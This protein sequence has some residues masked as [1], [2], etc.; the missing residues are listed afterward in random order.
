[1]ND[2]DTQKI[3]L[4]TG[5][6]LGKKDAPIKLVEF[7]NLRCPFC[8][9]WWEER[10]KLIAKYVA[11]GKIQ[12][13]IKLFDKDKASLAAGN[14]M[15][16]HVPEDE[17]ATKVITTIFE[18]QD[19]WGELDSLEDVANYAKQELGLTLQKTEHTSEAIKKE[20]AASGVFF[21]PTMIIGD[22]VFDQKISDQDLEKLLNS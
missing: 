7:T 8:K 9:Q 13:I 19:D 21:I 4:T 6:I 11:E 5:I 15:H 3:D 10:Q 18:T 2:I 14:I 17:T 22:T 1:M 16:H 12:H 20:A